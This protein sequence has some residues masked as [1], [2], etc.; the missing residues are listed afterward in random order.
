MPTPPTGTA[1]CEAELGGV[2]ERPHTCDAAVG[3]CLHPQRGDICGVDDEH[4][5][6]I[7]GDSGSRQHATSNGTN[8]Q[9]CSPY[10]WRGCQ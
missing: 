1:K 6:G 5:P 8:A 3:I 10:G 9:P 2:S 7:G 4:L